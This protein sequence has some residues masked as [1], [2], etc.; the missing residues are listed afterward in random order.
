MDNISQR[1]PPQK[2]RFSLFALGRHLIFI[3]V[4]LAI[5]LLVFEFWGQLGH[6]MGTVLSMNDTSADKNNGEVTVTVLPPKPCPKDQ[7]C[8]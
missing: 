1:E 8:S 7:K 2:Q 3:A 5:T 4:A 6:A